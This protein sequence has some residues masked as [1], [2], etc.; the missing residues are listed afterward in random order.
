MLWADVLS[1]LP[2]PTSFLYTYSLALCT[3]RNHA[4]NFSGWN[5]GVG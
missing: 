5:V 2:F 1:A 4:A 3:E